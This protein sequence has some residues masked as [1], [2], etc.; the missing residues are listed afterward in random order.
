M[1]FLA[2]YMQEIHLFNLHSAKFV[3]NQQRTAT[4]SRRKCCTLE[5]TSYIREKQHIIPR[6]WI[7]GAS[8]S[9]H[10]HGSLDR[11]YT[12]IIRNYTEVYGNIRNI[13]NYTE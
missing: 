4:K 11:N 10:I 6:D 2:S 7:W 8:L 1:D 12:E 3:G 5:H 13:R 9:I